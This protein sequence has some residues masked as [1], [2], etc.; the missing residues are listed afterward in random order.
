MHRRTL[1]KLATLTG[2]AAKPS[3][4]LRA[5]EGSAGQDRQKVHTVLLVAKCHLDVGFTLTQAKVMSQYFHQHFPLAM[6]TAAGLR[7]AGGDRYTWTTGSWLVYEYLEQADGVQRRAMENAI[8]AGDIAWHALPFSWQ[9]EMLDRSMIDGAM[10]FSQTLDRRFGVTTIGAK[11]TDVP[12]HTRGIVAPLHDAGVHLLDI[13]VNAAST[14]PDVPEIFRWKEAS[15]KSVNVMYHRR[16]YGGVIEIPGTGIAVDV[17]VRNDNDG[18]HTVQEIAAMYAKLRARFPGAEIKAAT[19]NDVA[20]AVDRAVDL[21]VVTSE[22]GDTW[23]YGCASDPLKVA[24]FRSVAGQRKQWIAQGKFSSGDGTDLGLLRRLLLVAEHTWGTDTKSY[25]DTVHYTPAD[26]KAVKDHPGYAVMETSWK[27]KRDNVDAGLATL[28]AGLQQQARSE[29]ERLRASAPETSH[30]AAHEVSR[31]VETKHF[32]IAF[33]AA[34]GAIIR[35]RNK[36]TGVDWASVEHPLA[37]FSYQTLSAA[38][39]ADYLKRYLTKETE[40]GPKDFGKPG[41]DAF[42]AGAREWHPRVQRCMTSR[43]DGEDRVVLELGIVDTAAE[44]LGNVAWPRQIFVELRL[45]V[46]SARVEIDVCTLAKAEN[47][48]PEAMWLTFSPKGVVAQ[49]WEL[50]K[51][52]QMIRATDVVRGGGRAIH[53]VND[54]LRCRTAKGEGFTLRSLDAAVVAFGKR[55]P[56]NFSPELP[57]FGSGVHVSLYNNAW[58]TNYPQ[59]CGG[60]WRYRF[61]LLG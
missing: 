10:G 1:L 60:D 12:G 36:R 37:L 21:P 11:M 39:Y 46:T 40:W 41:I 32:S 45:P 49:S 6:K 31:P 18:P 30:M 8:A 38:E 47:R 43:A 27:E 14:P 50:E 55:S 54:S 13:G 42:G 26:L 34:T 20:R 7:N 57:D 35:L 15:G 3:S 28:P 22:I 5:L 25:L 44:A 29:W 51:A 17:E 53:A 2:L 58:G 16:D 52:G 9:T 56:I 61:E 4:W 23:I 19:M 48:M 24:R 59:W 33:D